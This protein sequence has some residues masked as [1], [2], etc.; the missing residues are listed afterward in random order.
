MRKIGFCHGATFK[1]LDKYS[2]TNIS[3]FKKSGC[4][5]I[6]INC[7]SISE[8]DRFKSIEELIIDF[9]YK[10]IHLPCDLKY[11]DDE[12][13]NRLLIK[14]VKYYKKI[15]AELAVVHPDLIEDVGVFAKYPEISWAIE[16]MDDRKAKFKNVDDLKKFFEINKQWGFVLDVG[17]CNANDKTMKLADDFIAELKH[18]VK[19]IHLSGYEVFHDPLY[20]TKQNEIIERCK[21]FDV[22][23]II[24]STLEKTD[25]VNGVAKEF[26][27][28]LENLA[29]PS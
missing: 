18:K 13:T 29:L 28:I 20:R 6:E 5:A 21:Q 11:R 2:E 12:T 9:E 19:E 1:I 14:I 25:G 10:S 7:H 15:G 16:N 23:I 3:L 26:G 4:N 17:H 24:E 22:P 27:Y 8:A